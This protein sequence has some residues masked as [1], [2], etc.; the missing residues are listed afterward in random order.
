[1][2]YSIQ[3]KD[4]GG[5]IYVGVTG[6]NVVGNGTALYGKLSVVGDDEWMNSYGGSDSV[7]GPDFFYSIAIAKDGSSI[8]AGYTGSNDRDVSGNHGY[9]DYWVVKFGWH[10][11]VDDVIN[12]KNVVIAPNPANQYISISASELITDVAITNIVG[13][14]VFSG[15]CNAEKVQ[16]DVS[17]MSEGMYFV[18]VNG[19]EIR[20]FIKE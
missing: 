14:V 20:R 13:Q 15:A 9:Q 12:N 4:D 3:Q 10:T 6:A 19:T 11:K 5:Y 2:I 8:A 7:L 16:I 1:M 17:G 18:K